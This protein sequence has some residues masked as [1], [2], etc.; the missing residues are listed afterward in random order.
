MSDV[1]PRRRIAHCQFDRVPCRALVGR[2][3]RGEDQPLQSADRPR[4]FSE[5]VGQIQ[6]RPERA[7]TG[8]VGELC[9]EHLEQRTFGIG[10]QSP[11]KITE[12]QADG[13]WCQECGAAEGR[14]GVIERFRV[15]APREQLTSQIREIAQ[16]VLRHIAREGGVRHHLEQ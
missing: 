7:A 1:V 12:V 4:P 3:A 11:A 16:A 10:G 5:T 14:F 13:T 2:T 6:G 15:D 8:L 9:A